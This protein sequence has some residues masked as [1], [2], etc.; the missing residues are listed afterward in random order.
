MNLR[1]AFVGGPAD[2]QVRD[3]PSL[4]GPVPRLWWP[5]PEE[6]G[7]GAVY[8]SIDAAP[9]PESDRWRYRIADEQ[10]STSS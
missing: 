4:A 10:Q 3:Y 9:D 1:V 5:D 6:I 2:G 8:E 7:R